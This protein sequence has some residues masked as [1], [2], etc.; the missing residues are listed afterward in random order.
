MHQFDVFGRQGNVLTLS[1]I[2]PS[3]PLMA[4]DKDD[5]PDE[6]W[7]DKVE[8][9]PSQ[10]TAKRPI[11]HLSLTPSTLVEATSYL[12]R[13]DTRVSQERSRN[14]TQFIPAKSNRWLLTYVYYR[15]L[16]LDFAPPCPLGKIGSP[17]YKRNDDSDE[18]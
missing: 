12:D 10:V 5:H 13:V 3:A 2:G 14:V 8:S 18:A 17:E 4:I 6:V 15:C 7:Q 16:H 11:W 1:S 9:S